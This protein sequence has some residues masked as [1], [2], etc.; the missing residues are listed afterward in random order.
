MIV[1]LVGAGAQAKYALEIFTVRGDIKAAGLVDIMDNHKIWGKSLYGV[2]VLGGLETIEEAAAQGVTYA[3]VCCGD[4]H[5]KAELT[6]RVCAAGFQLTNA[7]HPRAT[8]ASSAELG[9][10][11][12]V[13][14]GAIIQP[15]AR[16]GDGVMV[17]AGVIIEHDNVIEDFANLAPGIKLAGWVRVKAYATVYTGAVVIP[18][19]TIGRGAVVGA[20]SVVLE[21][22]PDGVTVAGVPARVVRRAGEV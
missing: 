19:K 6:G 22:V 9:R 16:I 5:R 17:H 14:A 8:I 12:I 4:P 13:N 11:I 21:D 2:P 7:L 15:L 20:G 3:L 18:S 1:L 10:G